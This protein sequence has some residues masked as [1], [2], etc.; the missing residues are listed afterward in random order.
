[1]SDFEDIQ[2]SVGEAIEASNNFTDM[3]DEEADEAAAEMEMLDL[4][5]SRDE[6][7][8]IAIAIT[9]SLRLDGEIPEDIDT[10]IAQLEARDRYRFGGL[11]AVDDHLGDQLPGETGMDEG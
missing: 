7:R 5:I 6:S 1:M 8:A 9:E 10:M 11:E 3:T 4:G 2:K